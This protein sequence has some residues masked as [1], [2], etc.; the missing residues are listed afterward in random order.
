[1]QA[2]L[3]EPISIVRIRGFQKFLVDFKYLLLE[4]LL[5]IRHTWYWHITFA[6][7]L[8]IAFV[9]GFGRIGGDGTSLERILYII[10]GSAIFTVANDGLFVMASRIGVMRRDGILVYYASLPISNS[11]FLMSMM[12]S[13]LLITLPGMIVP[14]FF[15]AWLYQVPLSF[16]LWILLLLPIS[17]L[18][19]ASMGMALGVLVE[20]L[21]ILHMITNILMF[22]LVMATPMFIPIEALPLPLQIFGYLMPPTYAAEALRDALQGSI[23]TS[24]FMNLGILFS[25]AIVGFVLINRWLRVHI[26]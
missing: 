17:G 11:A 13:R 15:G 2:K 3:T 23:A 1:M 14:I 16:N 18:A 12:I 19:L 8:P 24:F 10:S 21:E 9:F 5:E 7:L 25:M 26:V 20:N 22:V 6:I 4:Q